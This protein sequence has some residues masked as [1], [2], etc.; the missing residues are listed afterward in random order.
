MLTDSPS[1]PVLSLVSEMGWLPWAMY[2]GAVPW[3]ARG[4]GEKG[5]REGQE[6]RLE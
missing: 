5:I 1:E 2:A 4:C 3:V 6:S